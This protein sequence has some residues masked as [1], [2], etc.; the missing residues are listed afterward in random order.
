MKRLARALIHPLVRLPILLVIYLGYGNFRSLHEP[1]LEA[2]ARSE[3]V[4]AIAVPS[5]SI[6]AS[7][8]PDCMS[9]A[10]NTKKRHKLLD[11]EDD[12][13]C[14]VPKKPRSEAH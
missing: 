8:V 3:K 11:S 12:E 4:K 9:S 5:P 14:V 6:S 10:E 13:T 2:E 1:R 7:A